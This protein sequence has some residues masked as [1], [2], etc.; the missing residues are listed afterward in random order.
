M[1]PA[2]LLAECEARGIRLS[3]AGAARL[4]IDGPAR[5]LTPDLIASLKAAK[6]GLLALLL[7]PAALAA[8]ED[9]R[10]VDARPDA[11]AVWQA[12]LN[13]LS[14]DPLFPAHVLEGMRAAE[15]RWTDMRAGESCLAPACRCG[16]TTWRD[17]PIH[18]GQSLR[19]DCAA[20]RRFIKF[21]VWYG[22]ILDNT[23]STAIMTAC[24]RNER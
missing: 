13:W 9:D 16:S 7:R 2:N 19:R 8:H 4:A 21:A 17:V 10:R 1:T 14:D 18:G 12:A 11:A 24:P 15:V 23:D 6:L 3:P 20:C 5:A 22:R